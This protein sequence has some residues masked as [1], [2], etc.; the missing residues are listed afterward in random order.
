MGDCE[1]N[2]NDAGYLEKLY[3]AFAYACKLTQACVRSADF[4][5][6]TRSHS[7]IPCVEN[8]SNGAHHTD[9]VVM[10]KCKNR[11]AIE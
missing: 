8:N 1:L 2:S 6:R 5:A 10:W 3:L 11:L 7:S 4:L 9:R